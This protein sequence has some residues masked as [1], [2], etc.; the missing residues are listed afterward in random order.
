MHASLTKLPANHPPSLISKSLIK[1]TRLKNNRHLS[2]N[3]QQL[4]PKL[5]HSPLSTLTCN[6]Q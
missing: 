2:K 5:A 3:T 4:E 1:N 6:K